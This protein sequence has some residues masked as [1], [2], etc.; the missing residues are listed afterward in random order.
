MTTSIL[1]LVCF[2]LGIVSGLRSMMG[3]ALVCWAVHLGWLNLAGTKLAFLGSPISLGIFSLLAIGELVADKLPFIP[4][5]IQAPSLTVRFVFGALAA[6][7]LAMAAGAGFGIPAL[8]G[9]IAAVIGAFAGYWVR[10]TVESQFNLKDALVAPV[11]D[12]I[13]ILLGLFAVSRF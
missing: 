5:R 6:C 2:L 3:V 7:A 10:R 12:L 8:V 9:G 1:L 11:E 13:A 4:P